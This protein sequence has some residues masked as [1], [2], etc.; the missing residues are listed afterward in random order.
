M[1]HTLFYSARNY[2]PCFRE[3]QPKRSFSIKWKR[4]FWACFRE[5]WVYKFGH[6]TQLWKPPGSGP[7]LLPLAYVTKNV[8]VQNKVCKFQF[9]VIPADGIG[10]RLG[11]E[12]TMQE[13]LVTTCP[14]QF[15]IGTYHACPTTPPR[16]GKPPIKVSP[17]W[18]SASMVPSVVQLYTEVRCMGVCKQ[19][20]DSI[21]P[22]SYASQISDR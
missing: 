13:Q 2:R 9:I 18:P 15:H 7:L 14:L 21:Y 6:R 5:N 17:L 12:Q 16:L 20:A 4:A 3:N 8:L 19:I 10:T 1:T 22:S 11:T